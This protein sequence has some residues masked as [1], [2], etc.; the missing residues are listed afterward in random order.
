VAPALAPVARPEGD[1]QQAPRWRLGRRPALDGLRGLAFAMVLAGHAGWPVARTRAHELGVELF[2]VLSG[3][4]IT[5]LLLE[6]HERDGEV[7]LGRFYRRRAQRLLPALVFVCVA[8]LAVASW[9]NLLDWGGTRRGVIGG[10]TYSSGVERVHGWDLGP[11]GHL[12]SLAVEEHF[13]LFWPLLLL[14]LLALRRRTWL[15]AAPAGLAAAVLIW[16]VWLLVGGRGDLDT[17]NTRLYYPTDTRV[18][19]PLAGCALAVVMVRFGASWAARWALPLGVAALVLLTWLSSGPV[20]TDRPWLFI[21]GLPLAAL[22]GIALCV[23]AATTPNI[24]A[25]ALSWRPL[26]WLGGISYGGYLVHYPIYFA[27]GYEL[28]GMST[29]QAVPVIALSVLAGAAVERFVE[30]P[31]RRGRRPTPVPAADQRT[32]GR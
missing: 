2:F 25:S 28:T 23:A 29:A 17:L 12:W 19:A 5:A 11:L 16:R 27:F 6:E 1:V 31:F 4:L 14:G 22:S 3:F 24:V 20:I 10:L 7:A 30:R 8:C 9:T 18:M 32:F 15:L 21:A 26:T 13:Y